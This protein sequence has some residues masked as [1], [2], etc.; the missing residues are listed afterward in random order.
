MTAK[1][2]QTAECAPLSVAEPA[3]AYQTEAYANRFD[4]KISR[5]Y[6]TIDEYA[7]NLRVAI[8]QRYGYELI[9]KR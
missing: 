6:Y 9:T 5:Q 1:P 4:G 2:Y 3:V 8:N 7:E